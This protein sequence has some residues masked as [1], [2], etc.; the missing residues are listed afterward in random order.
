M[1]EVLANIAMG[2]VGLLLMV[3]GIKLFLASAAPHGLKFVVREVSQHFRTTPKS[4]Q[5]QDHLEAAAIAICF[6]KEHSSP[7]DRSLAYGFGIRKNEVAQMVRKGKW[8]IESS[9]EL[10]AFYENLD[11][12]FANAG[13][14]ELW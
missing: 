11:V 2:V 4:V 13:W 7:S 8:L 14:W 10:K 6:L 12:K 1:L 3:L 5:N 9:E